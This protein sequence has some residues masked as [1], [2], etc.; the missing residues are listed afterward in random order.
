M[1]KLGE[2][3]NGLYSTNN[4]GQASSLPLKNASQA[5]SLRHFSPEFDVFAYRSSGTT[6][7]IDAISTSLK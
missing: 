6:R 4:V 2:Q 1:A 5:G 3:I 7:R